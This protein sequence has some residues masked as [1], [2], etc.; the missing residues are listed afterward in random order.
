MNSTFK[1]IFEC[2]QTPSTSK[3]LRLHNNL[4]FIGKYI[5]N[6][7]FHFSNGTNGNTLWDIDPI[8]SHQ[9]S[10]LV[11]MDIEAAELLLLPFPGDGKRAGGEFS[12]QSSHHS[13]D[14]K[15]D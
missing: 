15:H 5:L 8:I 9:L 12:K 4:I 10:T 2:P 3:H 7:L 13:S 14:P 1:S 11:F 6:R